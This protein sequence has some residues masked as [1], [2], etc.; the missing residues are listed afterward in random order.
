MAQSAYFEGQLLVAMP[1]IEDP[2]FERSVIFLCSHSAEGAM[3][4]IVNR[5]LPGLTF[6]MLMSQLELE[7]KAADEKRP[8][9]AGGPVETGR[10]FVLHSAEFRQ[11]STL[12]IG[13]ASSIALT[14]TVDILK[15]LADG[16]GPK[17]AI[18]AL[19]YA[20]W[21]AGQLDR[22]LT[23]NGWLTAE[24]SP[25]LLFE[26]PDEQKWPRA[27]ESLGISV[28]LLSGEAGHA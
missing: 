12:V 14:A 9:Y 13:E 16:Q 4:L 23:K 17:Q 11:D 24:A 6:N 19:G 1:S 5:Q 27:I 15:A 7:G 22:E 2:R 21:A 26:T 25:H 10:G 3:G 28:S 18:I 8:I 20:G